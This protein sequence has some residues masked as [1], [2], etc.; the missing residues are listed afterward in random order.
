V[1][2]I[3]PR[4]H[5]LALRLASIFISSLLTLVVL[6]LVYAFGFQGSY[7]KP[8]ATD[9]WFN[10]VSRDDNLPDDELGFA[11]KPGIFWQGRISPEGGYLSY[12]TDENGFRNAP[13]VRRADIVFV[14]DSFT[15][16]ASVPEED[17]F[18][19]QLGK[20]V[21][22]SVVN[23]GR[24]F[25][26]P[27]QEL[28]VL[29]RYGLGYDPRVVVWQLFEGND[30]SDATRFAEWRKNPVRT[31][32]LV[33]RYFWHSLITH[34]LDHTLPKP[35][36]T[37]P[38]I[39]FTDGTTSP[40]DLGY[41]YLPDEPA[42]EA[43]GFAETKSAIEAGYRLCESRGIRLLVIFVPIKARVLAP[44]VVFKDEQERER[45]LPGGVA[46]SERDFA[47]EMA[48]FCRQINCPFIDMTDGLRRRAAENNHFLYMTGEDSH[49][50][51]EGHR[52][53][54]EN[55]KAWLQTN[56]GDAFTSNTG[57]GK[58]LANSV[59]GRTR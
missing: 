47:H 35:V 30:L 11:R 16:G 54:A 3:G 4:H 31:E 50:D 36:V 8:T 28:I 33:Q 43:L 44:Y 27:Q 56:L 9:I 45:Y 13:Q 23:L 26:G 38:K 14:G 58:S 41:S 2:S 10:T 22:H 19:Q 6:D 18:V 39:Q 21:K 34:W 17:T 5:R 46:D 37:P 42:H 51:V 40:L 55:I 15:E 49:L 48:K 53:V 52:V 25:Y 20:E 1:Y 12:R 57:N 7:R 24:G 59:Q 29:R 32:S